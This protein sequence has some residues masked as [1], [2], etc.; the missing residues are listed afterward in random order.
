[1][2]I[3]HQNKAQI[4]HFLGI[5][6]GAADMGLALADEETKMAFA[7]KKLKNDKQFLQNLAEIIEKENVKTVIIGVPTYIYPHTNLKVK[8][9]KRN[10]CL[11]GSIKREIGVGVN[12]EEVEY[13][14]EKFGK[15]LEKT[16]GVEVEYQNEM[17]TT[18]LAQAHLIEKRVKGIKRFD[19]QEAARIILQE[20][21]DRN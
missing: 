6:Y 12:R 21:I 20:W 19:D 14:S 3:D 1:M 11:S 13:D 5:D 9:N 16:F 7:Y 8:K 4:K 2:S 10:K 15:L 18:K 17:F